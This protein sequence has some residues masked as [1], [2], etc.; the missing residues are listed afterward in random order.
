MPTGNSQLPLPST[1]D[2]VV[3]GTHRAKPSDLSSTDEA[4]GSGPQSAPSSLKNPPRGPMPLM[5]AAEAKHSIPAPGFELR[6]R[7]VN[8]RVNEKR[9]VESLHVERIQKVATRLVMDM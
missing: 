7:W 2:T 1:S 5:A 9:A 8:T 3:P 4:T 6:W